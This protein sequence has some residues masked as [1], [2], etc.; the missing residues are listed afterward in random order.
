MLR[1]TLDAIH[2]VDTI[3]RTGSF[4]AAAAQ[5]H[6]VPS[7]ISYT[8]N[9]LEEQL[10]VRLFERNGPHVSLTPSGKELLEEGRCLLSAAEDLEVRL[11]RLSRGVEISLNIMLDELLPIQVFADDI[12][13]FQAEYPSTRLQLGRQVMTGTW[14]ALIQGWADLVIAAGEGPAGGGYKT[15]PVGSLSF[16]FCVAPDHPLVQVNSPLSKD[17]LL[18]YNAIV[19]TDTARTLPAR[20]VGL[21]TGQ[22]QLTVAGLQ[23][24]IALQKAGL[25]HGFLPRECIAGDLQSGAL[26]EL[27]VAEPKADESFYLAWR[28]NHKGEALKW[29][30]ER[31]SQEL[32][33]MIFR[34]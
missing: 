32:L 14:E 18:R 6:K 10:G 26:V 15:F 16:A 28:T 17:Q 5:L 1:L 24:K 29:W 23:D 11:Q 27:N 20:S 12:Q 2:I 33:P 34:Y 3:A 25:G 31:L 13:A 8:I 7:T 9:K 4:T 19:I 30:R 22:K 21:M